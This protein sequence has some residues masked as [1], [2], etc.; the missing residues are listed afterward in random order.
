MVT[1]RP[2]VIYIIAMRTADKRAGVKVEATNTGWLPRRV[3]LGNYQ[4]NKAI[5]GQ[6]PKLTLLKVPST[7]VECTGVHRLLEK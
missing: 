6:T 1:Y 7:R 5:T 4:S 3:S 2:W